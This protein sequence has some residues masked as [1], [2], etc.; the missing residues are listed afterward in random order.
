MDMACTLGGAA[1]LLVWQAPVLLLAL[2]LLSVIY[3]RV[4]A[5]MPLRPP[6]ALAPAREHSSG[7][8]LVTAASPLAGGS[9]QARAGS[10]SHARACSTLCLSASASRRARCCV[11]RWVI[12]S[13]QTGRL[14]RMCDGAEAAGGELPEPRLYPLRPDAPRA[15]HHPADGGVWQ[16]GDSHVGGYRRQHRC[17]S[18]LGAPQQVA[19]TATGAPSLAP[20][21]LGLAR[22]KHAASPRCASFCEVAPLHSPC[23]LTMWRR[24]VAGG[25]ARLPGS[26]RHRPHRLR[27]R[28]LLILLWRR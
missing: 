27:L 3:L 7:Q 11:L 12:G 5:S 4:Q 17:L 8:Q 25:A 26:R 13:G 2:A 14:Q 10:P 15:G 16:A 23:L 1:V 9:Q 22:S 6:C 19:P 18:R 24:Q 20:R 21:C 28:R